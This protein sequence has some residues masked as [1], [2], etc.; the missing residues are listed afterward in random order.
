MHTG[1]GVFIV[2]EG[3]DGSGKGT[4]FTRLTERLTNEGYDVATFDFPQYD[5]PSSY[6]VKEYL[7]GKYGGPNEVGP[8][9]GSLFY[10]LD[11]FEA[12]PKIRQALD[13]GKVVLANRYVGSNMAH[14]GTKFT[15]AEERRGY[16]IWLDNLE[17][18]MLKSPR[19]TLSFVL[20]VPAE[21]SQQLVDKKAARS[22]TDRKRDIHEAD[23]DHLKKALA[24]YDDMCQ[25]FPKDFQRIDCTRDDALL[26]IDAVH[27][28]IWQKVLP[29]LPSKKKTKPATA[30]TSAADA[31]AATVAV[32]EPQTPKAEAP[33]P[34][35]AKPAS[36][37]SDSLSM[38]ASSLLLQKLRST[39]GAI[40]TEANPLGLKQEDGTYAY[41]I[42]PYFDQHVREQ[43]QSYMDQIFATYDTIKT[44]LESHLDDAA[45]ATVI[46]RQVL[47]VAAIQAITI[48]AD[49]T[50]LGHLLSSLLSDTIPG[51]QR[52]AQ[53]LLAEVKANRPTFFHDQATFEQNKI[54]VTY[55]ATRQQ[56]LQ[57]LVKQQLPDHHTEA[58]G[59]ARLINVWP[60]NEFDSVSDMIYGLTNLPL[61]DIK[62]QTASW[63]Y[64]KKVAVLEAYLGNRENRYQLP[65]MALQN[66]HYTWDL[67]TSYDVLHTLQAGKHAAQALWQE[68]TPRYG[69]EVPQAIDDAGL[70]DQFE[71][72]FDL[73]LRLHS[74]LQGAGY[75]TESQYAT[76]HGHQLRWTMQHTAYEAISFI[77]TPQA[78]KAAQ[79]LQATLREKISDVH[80]TIGDAITDAS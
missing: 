44:S 73:S 56:K 30:Q 27:D 51:I 48:Q 69:Y 52:A 71:A 64:D 53:T 34:A 16:F 1:R 55:A 2:I 49:D 20:R 59:S 33:E 58:A 42:P 5:Q 17:F 10:A 79:Q 12:A 66:I 32:S 57:S 22:Y 19:P 75:Q 45:K 68:L 54:A 8:Y 65:G 62:Q 50:A 7:N 74:L 43:Y 21:I 25:L 80:P 39:S 41:Y 35:A 77:E 78:T 14:Q 76:L 29:M 26:E 36:P 31:P 23:L 11:R 9:T 24:V 60:R 70:T 47:P 40:I 46:A 63:P 6:F 37:T 18:E 28:I 4:Q 61:Q 67:V 72:C 13:A 3:T 15:H 38:Q